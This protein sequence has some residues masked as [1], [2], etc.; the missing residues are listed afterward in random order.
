MKILLS[1]AKSLDYDSKA[2]TTKY[3]KPLMV[4]DSAELIADLKQLTAHQIGD[5]MKVSEK[6]AQLNFDRFQEWSRDFTIANSKQAIFAFKGDVYQGLDAESL[7]SNEIITAQETIC[8]LSGLYGI[9]RPLDL[10]QPYR[11]E[12]GTRFINARGSN[13]YQFWGSKISEYLNSVESEVVVNLAS[14]EYSKALERKALRARV[15]DI[16]FKEHKDGELKTIGIYAKKARGLMARYAVKNRIT[17][18]DGL[19]NFDN[20]GYKFSDE[21]STMIKLVFI[22]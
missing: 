16:D 1:P 17:S 13:L 19:K 21:L 12:M 4:D 15:V 7:S 9:L 11:L 2:P 22:R 14:T 10:M 18:S 6:I 8:I 3:N 20:A 5:L